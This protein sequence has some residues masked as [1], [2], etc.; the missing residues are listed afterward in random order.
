MKERSDV[1]LLESL[2]QLTTPQL[3][4]MLRAELEK[5]LPEEHTVRLILKVLRS[6][7]ADCPVVHNEQIDAA[8]ETYRRKVDSAADKPGKSLRKAAA[9]VIL[10]GLLLVSLPQNAAARG[11]FDRI[12]AWTGSIFSLLS[13]GD[14]DNPSKE[15][16]FRTE[17]PGLQELYDSLVELGVTTPVVPT[18]LDVEYELDRCTVNTTRITTKVRAVFNSEHDEVLIEVNIY[19]N[20]IPREFHKEEQPVEIHE[21]NGTDYYIFRNKE[22]WTVVWAKDNI[23]CSLYIDCQ[24]DVLYKILDSI[25]TVED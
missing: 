25:Y 9:I 3:D 6:R 23:E 12:A 4:D 7:E 15:Y 24:E 17:H 21:Y 20:S 10:C 2:K 14:P 18:W 1:S 13:P 5:E 19:S 8:L 22:M 16:V 11:L